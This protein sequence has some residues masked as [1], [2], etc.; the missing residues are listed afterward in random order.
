MPH[1]AKRRGS[2]DVAGTGGNRLQTS[3]IWLQQDLF[4]FAWWLWGG[5]KNIPCFC[6]SS[7]YCFYSI[8]LP[9]FFVSLSHTHTNVVW[10]E[11]AMVLCMVLKESS[12]PQLFSSHYKLTSQT[13]FL[14]SS[15]SIYTVQAFVLTAV[16][17]FLKQPMKAMGDSTQPGKPPETQ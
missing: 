17:A 1:T 15:S 5:N 4:C 11:S 10:D 13:P 2:L 7:L 9:Q 8:C 6:T 3:W 12:A 14:W 16:I